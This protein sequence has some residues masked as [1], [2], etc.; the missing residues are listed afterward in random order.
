MPRKA[1]AGYTH[2]EDAVEKWG[3]YRT[4]WY[5]QVREG[6]L[7]GYDIPGERGTFLRDEEAA[8]LAE[9]RPKGQQQDV[10]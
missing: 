9:P 1:P 2:I 5:E 8:P 6:R 7:T 3:K 10:G 4:W